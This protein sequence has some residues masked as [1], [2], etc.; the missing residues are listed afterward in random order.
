LSSPTID[1]GLPPTDSRAVEA[2]RQRLADVAQACVHD[3]WAPGTYKTYENTLRVNVG[4]AEVS[5]GAALLPM[6]SEGKFMA[7]FAA[8][9][10]KNWDS[11]RILKSAVRAWH[12]SHQCLSAFDNAW[13]DN[14][15]RFW[16]GLKRRASHTSRAKEPVS[17]EELDDFCRARLSQNTPAGLRDA[18]TA[19]TDFFG[20][21]RCSEHIALLRSHVAFPPGAVGE[22][23]VNIFISKQKND[24]CGKG[25]TCVVPEMPQKGI[26]CPY[27]LLRKW[28]AYWDQN[29]GAG[30]AARPFF[31]VTGKAAPRHTSYDSWRKTVASHFQSPDKATHSF[32]KGGAHWYKQV[33]AVPDSAVQAQGG[34]ASAATM[35]RVYSGLT[36]SERQSALLAGARAAAGQLRA[37]VPAADAITKPAPPPRLEA[38]PAPAAS[39]K[40]PPEP[41]AKAR[42]AKRS[43][44]N[45][46][47]RAQEELM[48]LDPVYEF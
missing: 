14:A 40:Q 4:D 13:T 41:P 7:A 5:V 32:R 1:L 23:H 31:C 27:Q 2:E 26:L 24:P 34:W 38:R 29:F 42:G 12:I 16:E 22:R 25:L 39:S 46:E 17:A 10:G 11:V 28:A 33:A 20:V 3:S 15:L 8:M 47:T 21:R 9:D 48:A 43:R 37:S 6:D 44:P 19:V 30:N 45:S 36:T 18:A 35:E